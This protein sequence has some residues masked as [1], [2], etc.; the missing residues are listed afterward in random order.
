MR[1]ITNHYLLRPAVTAFS[2]LVSIC[3]YLLFS[4][5][6]LPLEAMVVLFSASS[7]C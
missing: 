7:F 3:Y 1:I 4:L 2:T 5:V 6:L